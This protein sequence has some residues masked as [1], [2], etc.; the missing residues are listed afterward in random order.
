MEKL[1]PKKHIQK[2]TNHIVS[3]I[4]QIPHTNIIS[5]IIFYSIQNPWTI[6]N[7]KKL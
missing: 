6:S 5:T 3:F 4:A 7:Y 2:Q 1:S